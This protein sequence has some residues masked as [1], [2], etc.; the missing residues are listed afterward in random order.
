MKLSEIKYEVKKVSFS[1]FLSFFLFSRF[2]FQYKEADVDCFKG[3]DCFVK[4]GV[5]S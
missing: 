3:F 2:E 4:D 1:L 5:V